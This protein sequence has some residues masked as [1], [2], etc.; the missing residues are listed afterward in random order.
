[1]EGITRE[2]LVQ[3]KQLIEGSS[4]G[5]TDLHKIFCMQW[6]KGNALQGKLLSKL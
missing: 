1:M 2:L 6:D 5:T 4:N 3:Q